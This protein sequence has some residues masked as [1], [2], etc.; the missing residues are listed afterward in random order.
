M[1]RSMEQTTA[2]R[3]FVAEHRSGRPW[4]QMSSQVRAVVCVV[5]CSVEVEFERSVVW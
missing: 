3:A 5:E 4:R 2:G 1:C